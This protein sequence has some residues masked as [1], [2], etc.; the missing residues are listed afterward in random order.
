MIPTVVRQLHAAW[1]QSGAA[2]AFGRDRGG[3]ALV[4]TPLLASFAPRRSA[5]QE[6]AVYRDAEGRVLALGDLVRVAHS[7]R[8]YVVLDFVEV[9]EPF[10]GQRFVV[11]RGAY[12]QGHWQDVSQPVRPP[13]GDRFAVLDNGRLPSVRLVRKDVL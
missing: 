5:L 8:R 12:G 3:R 1:R 2:V 7:G 6:P 11:E 10:M 13:V 4:R 9:Y